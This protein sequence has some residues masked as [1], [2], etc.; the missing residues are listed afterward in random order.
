MVEGKRKCDE[1]IMRKERVGFAIKRREREKRK[2]SLRKVK[3]KEVQ[4]EGRGTGRRV[5]P[6][7]RRKEKGKHG[8][9]E[10]RKRKFLG[11]IRK[12]ETGE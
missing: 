5:F 9:R 7:K 6:E 12:K 2:M 1:R 11:K 3:R 10:M 4:P 8:K